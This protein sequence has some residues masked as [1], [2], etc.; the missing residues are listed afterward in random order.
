MSAACSGRLSRSPLRVLEVILVITSFAI[1]LILFAMVLFALVC[2]FPVVTL[3]KYQDRTPV[4]VES[5]IA[6]QKDIGALLT[7]SSMSG[8]LNASSACT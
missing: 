8:A 3:H 5:F 6:K 2:K 4:F 7:V 1:V